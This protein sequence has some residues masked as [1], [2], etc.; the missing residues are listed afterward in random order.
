L[1]FRKLLILCKSDFLSRISIVTTAILNHQTQ[2]AMK[3]RMNENVVKGVLIFCIFMVLALKSCTSLAQEFP[4][5]HT[6][7]YYGFDASFGVRLFTLHSDLDKINGMN[8]QEE[9]GCM[10]LVIG[11]KIWQ[12]KLRQGFFYSAANVPY[13]TDLVET[14]LNLNINPLQI[15]K[16]RFRSFE[17]YITTGVERNA[18]KLYGS[19]VKIDRAHD[20]AGLVNANTEPYLGQIVIT[21]VGVGGGLQ[22]RVPYHR[23]FL[24]LFAEARYGYALANNTSSTWFKYT[25]VSSQA[26]ISVGVSFGYLHK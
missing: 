14:E 8:V 3:T 18:I 7:V 15:I 20:A 25:T 6:I 13:T 21:R 10:G 2:K 1:L 17:P 16:S 23:S 12:T 26:A 19:Y 5:K 9:G 22:Y 11:N 4:T 24:R